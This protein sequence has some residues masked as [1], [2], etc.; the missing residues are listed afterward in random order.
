M[1][2][3]VTLSLTLGQ[4]IAL[5]DAICG[6][7]YPGCVTLKKSMDKQIEEQLEGTK[8]LKVY[9]QLR[10]VQG[11]GEGASFIKQLIKCGEM[12]Q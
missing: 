10:A 12:M 1:K 5:H 6:A 2:T 4:A 7:E 3:R 11:S 9:K 8:D